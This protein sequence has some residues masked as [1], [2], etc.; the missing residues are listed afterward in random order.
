MLSDIVTSLDLKVAPILAND[1]LI[2]VDVIFVI[3]SH[4]INGLIVQNDS[5][6]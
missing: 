4:S 6:T 5:D 2:R 1:V 3:T